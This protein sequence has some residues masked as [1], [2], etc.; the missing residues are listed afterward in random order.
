MALLSS[1]GSDQD[2]FRYS[3]QGLPFSSNG[4]QNLAFWQYFLLGL[5]ILKEISYKKREGE[6]ILYL[7]FGVG[8]VGGV[9]R[10]FLSR[11]REREKGI[12]CGWNNRWEWVEGGRL[13]RKCCVGGTSN[14]FFFLLLF[15]VKGGLS[16]HKHIYWNLIWQDLRGSILFILSTAI[17]IFD[18]DGSFD[19]PPPLIALWTSTSTSPSPS[20][21]FFSLFGVFTFK[22]GPCGSHTNK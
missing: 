14:S 3:S 8:I 20:P 5:R 10:V 18:M 13:P 19:V 9:E 11:G 12:D 15:V 1:A 16:G 2:P 22:G 21:L 7:L 4:E 6:R 17:D